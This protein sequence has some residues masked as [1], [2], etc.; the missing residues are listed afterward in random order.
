MRGAPFNL[1][2]GDLVAYRPLPSLEQYYIGVIIDC[3]INL[4]NL[5]YHDWFYKIFASRKIEWVSAECLY[6]LQQ[7]K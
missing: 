2:P 4:N 1:K 3:E 6:N 5:N 7:Y